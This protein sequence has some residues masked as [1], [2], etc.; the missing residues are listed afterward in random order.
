MDE[1]VEM[2]DE[3]CNNP[4]LDGK[5][6]VISGIFEGISRNK[7]EEFCT[8]RGARV[9]TSV[10]GKTDMLIVG[11]QMEDGREITEG[12]KYKKALKMSTT[13]LTEAQF[14]EYCKQ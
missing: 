5:T 4:F 11:W 14:E 13:I 10:S 7:L 1:D 8:E 12:G 6:I 9:T 2:K 3:Q